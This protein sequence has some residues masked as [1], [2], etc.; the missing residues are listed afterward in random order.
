MNRFNNFIKRLLLKM[1]PYLGLCL[2]LLMNN[3]RIH[4]KSKLKILYKLHGMWV[5]FLLLYLLNLNLIKLLFN[6]LKLWIKKE[7]DMFYKFSL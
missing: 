6:K 7:R 5:L 3:A 2:V 4:I 1:I